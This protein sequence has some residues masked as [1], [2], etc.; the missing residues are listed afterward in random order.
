MDIVSRVVTPKATRAG[1]ACKIKLSC[2]DNVNGTF[3]LISNLWVQPEVYP[4]DN[5]KHTARHID[6]D[7]VVGELSLKYQ[8][9]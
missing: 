3:I 7:Q 2:Q 5:D 6:G 8:V 9:H 4:G 1:T